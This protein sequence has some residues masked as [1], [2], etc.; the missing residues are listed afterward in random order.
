[1]LVRSSWLEQDSC[2]Y[3]IASYSAHKH[4]MKDWHMVGFSDIYV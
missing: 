2:L 3:A 1:M 4:S